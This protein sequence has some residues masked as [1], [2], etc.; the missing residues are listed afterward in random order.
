MGIID[1]ICLICG[2]DNDL[3]D[4]HLTKVSLKKNPN[5]L[6][7]PKIKLCRTCHDLIE[8]DKQKMKWGKKLKKVRDKAYCQ[9]FADGQ[10]KLLGV[11][12]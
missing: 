6:I 4:H 3:T 5:P 10:D 12:P 1:E 7:I 2:S 9:G 8:F 11:S